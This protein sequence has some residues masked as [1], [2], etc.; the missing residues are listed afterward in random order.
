MPIL[1]V[2]KDLDVWKQAMD[3][4]EHCYRLSKGFPLDERFGLTN[5]LRRAAVFGRLKR[6]SNV[7]TPALTPSP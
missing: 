4:V 6:N 1:R 7:V 3:L 5:Q 2:Y